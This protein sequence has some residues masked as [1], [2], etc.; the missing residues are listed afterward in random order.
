MSAQF[1]LGQASKGLVFVVIVVVWYFIF[2]LPV[3]GIL[4]LLLFSHKSQCRGSGGCVS[5][6]KA[7][8]IIYPVL[9]PMTLNDFA[10]DATQDQRALSQKSA[11]IQA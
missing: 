3:S 4:W 9:Q 2:Y 1:P 6:R 5:V 10:R 8:R 7:E 11:R